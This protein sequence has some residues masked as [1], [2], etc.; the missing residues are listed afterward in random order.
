MASISVEK[1]REL[2][3]CGLRD[4]QAKN[5]LSGDEFQDLVVQAAV[6]FPRSKF[7][8]QVARE[9]QNNDRPLI[10]INLPSS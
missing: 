1:F 9:F 10:M 4:I 2:E 5:K 6:V 8:L 7:I 3:A